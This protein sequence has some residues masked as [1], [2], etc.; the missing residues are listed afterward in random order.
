MQSY[1]VMQSVNPYISAFIIAI[2][3]FLSGIVSA[4]S[5]NICV[6]NA[7]WGIFITDFGYAETMVD[8]RI[9]D[10]VDLRGREYLSG[11]WGAAI[12]YNKNA[13][14]VNPVWF[15]PNFLF[16]DWTTN[17][18]FIVISPIM[19]TTIN[20]TGQTVYESVIANNDLEIKIISEM[21]DTGDSTGIQQGLTPSSAAS[22]NIN[23][24]A[25]S[26]YIF[27][28]SYEVKNISGLSI[29]DIRIYQMLHG[30]QSLFSLYDDRFYPGTLT[31]NGP[32]GLDATHRYDTTLVGLDDNFSSFVDP[33]PCLFQPINLNIPA[34]GFSHTDI[35]S[36]Q[37]AVAPE[38]IDSDY[39]GNQ[40]AGDNHVFG[41]PSTGTHI[42][43]ETALLNNS[44]FFDP[45]NTDYPPSITNTATFGS[46]DVADLWVAGA[47]QHNLGSLNNND[48]TSHSYVL[49]VKSI[50]HDHRIGTNIPLPAWA[51]LVLAL[52]FIKLHIKLRSQLKE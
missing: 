51:Y 47:Q 49:S 22:I 17:S 12:S 38:S 44:D 1:V 36:L 25:S 37:S 45:G 6:A 40:G 5:N 16:P 34:E 11:E 26:Q 15:E 31:P 33:S 35:L 50:M 46:D 14:P 28:Q 39:Y 52:Y 20:A 30:L 21:I 24:E 41:K 42:N 23:A 43:I 8:L 13:L 32:L 18:N 9:V 29:T 10:G 2:A 19:A 27:K 48:V 4:Q 7:D 3:I